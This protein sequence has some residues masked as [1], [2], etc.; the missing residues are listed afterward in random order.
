[1]S[2]TR[3]LEKRLRVGPFGREVWEKNRAELALELFV[4]GGEL[5]KTAE[6]LDF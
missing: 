3:R 6:S 5:R 2:F 4:E 1:M